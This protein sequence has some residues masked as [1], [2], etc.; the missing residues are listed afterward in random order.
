MPARVILKRG[1]DSFL[2][3]CLVKGNDDGGGVVF[4]RREQHVLILVEFIIAVFS[5]IEKP[6][7]RRHHLND[8]V[9]VLMGARVNTVAADSLSV[10]DLILLLDL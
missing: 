1:I 8:R 9:I 3:S 2:L 4:V 5:G 7:Y 10:S 6:K